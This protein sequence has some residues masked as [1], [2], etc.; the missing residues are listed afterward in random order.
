MRT[1]PALH[2]DTVMPKHPSPLHQPLSDKRSCNRAFKKAEHVQVQVATLLVITTA[3]EVVEAAF[4]VSV[5]LP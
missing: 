3:K 4:P 2:S 1:K 5:C